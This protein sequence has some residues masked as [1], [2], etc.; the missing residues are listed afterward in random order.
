LELLCLSALTSFLPGSSSIL[1]IIHMA[2]LAH[3]TPH[4]CMLAKGMTAW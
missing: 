3:T 2:Q 1:T 4:C